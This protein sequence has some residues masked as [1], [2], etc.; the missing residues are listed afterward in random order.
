MYCQRGNIL[1]LNNKR[2]KKVII[3]AISTLCFMFLIGTN[4]SHAQELAGDE[5][6]LTTEQKVQKQTKTWVKALTLD[7][8]QEAKVSP[9]LL[10]R[11]KMR[12]SIR[13]SDNKR[14]AM[15]DFK[16]LVENQN[17][18]LKTILSAEQF[19]KY[20]QMRD[21]A[22]DKFKGRKKRGEQ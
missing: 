6:G 10:E 19:A 7:T 13:N 12:E 5:K 21:D 9:I 18:Q 1:N 8:D 22:V 2:M 15:K 4:F 3:S 14:Q 20:E 17:T 11:I 16:N